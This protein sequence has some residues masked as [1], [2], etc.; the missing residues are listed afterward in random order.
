MSF[1]PLA[2]WA[3][4]W[5]IAMDLN[6]YVRFKTTGR[7]GTTSGNEASVGIWIVGCLFFLF[8]GMIK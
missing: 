5:P 6:E 7:S 1:L 4:G 3:V 2:I 8:T